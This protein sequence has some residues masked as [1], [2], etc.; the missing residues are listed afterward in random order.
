MQTDLFLFLFDLGRIKLELQMY[1]KLISTYLV[2]IPKGTSISTV[3]AKR[4]YSDNSILHI[5][6]SILPIFK[7][8]LSLSKKFDLGEIRVNLKKMINPFD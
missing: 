5:F 7:S 4:F 8:I 6:N 2:I 1:V 3:S